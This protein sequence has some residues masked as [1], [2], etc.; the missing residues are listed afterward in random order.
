VL[1][2]RDVHPGSPVPDPD[3]NPSRILDLGSRITDPKTATKERG[4]KNFVVIPIFFVAANFTKL[5]IILIIKCRRKEFGPVF[6]EL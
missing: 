6:K 1:R 5:N 2:I 4:E 3:F